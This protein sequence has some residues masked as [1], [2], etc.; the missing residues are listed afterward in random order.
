[1]VRKL[2][3]FPAPLTDAAVASIVSLYAPGATV[4]IADY[5]GKIYRFQG[6]SGIGAYYNAF[7]GKGLGS[8]NTVRSLGKTTVIT[9]G[10]NQIPGH[11]VISRFADVFVVNGGKIRSEDRITFWR[12]PQ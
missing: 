10:R 3:S 6:R 9:Y 12:N 7:V 2:F 4:T 8:L 5:T 1:V 11:A